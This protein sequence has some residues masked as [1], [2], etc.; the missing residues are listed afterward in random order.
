MPMSAGAGAG[1]HVARVHLLPDVV[2]VR[3]RPPH[4]RRPGCGTGGVDTRSPF[5]R[6]HAG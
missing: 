3:H 5:L 2:R 4:P 1:G 6:W